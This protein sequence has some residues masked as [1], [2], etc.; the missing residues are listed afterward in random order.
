MNELKSLSVEQLNAIHAKL[1]EVLDILNPE[2]MTCT[3]LS[4]A[5]LKNALQIELLEIRVYS[6]I[7]KR[8]IK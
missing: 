3:E 7:C 2:K 5:G 1:G 4:E 6:E 8:I